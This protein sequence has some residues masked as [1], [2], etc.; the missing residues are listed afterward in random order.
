MGIDQNNLPWRCD[1]SQN[2]ARLRVSHAVE[3]GRLG[4][5]LLKINRG[6]FAEVEGVPVNHGLLAGL[7]DI[8]RIA[9][10]ADRGLTRTD[11]TARGQLDSRRRWGLWK[12][13][14]KR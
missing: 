12:R 1:A 7:V 5:G 10:L 2:L 13:L 3:R 9:R 8:E 4:I 14:R 6:V 11:L